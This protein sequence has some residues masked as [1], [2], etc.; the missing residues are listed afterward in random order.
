[1]RNSLPLHGL[2]RRTLACVFGPSRPAQFAATVPKLS[3]SQV[4]WRGVPAGKL[5]S[6]APRPDGHP[7]CYMTA[8]VPQSSKYYDV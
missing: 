7:N 4:P 6:T 1:M 2:R 5:A 3:Q 8:L